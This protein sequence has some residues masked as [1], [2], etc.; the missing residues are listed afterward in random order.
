MA[1][2]VALEAGSTEAEAEAML[3]AAWQQVEAFTGKTYRTTTSGTVIVKVSSP[4]V[5]TWPRYPFPEALTIEAYSQ[6]AWVAWSETYIAAA[7]LI[8]LE[9]FTLYRLSHT[10]NVPAATITPAVTQAVHNLALYQLIQGP[11]RREFK[12]QQAGDSG[13]TREQLMPVFYGS[14]AGALL[15]SEVRL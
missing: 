11:S 3:S 15:A 13:F 1:S 10:D 9:P 5:W 6:G 12:S 8:E 14:G 4:T 2:D 7:G